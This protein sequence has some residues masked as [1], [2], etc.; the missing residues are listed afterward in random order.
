MRTTELLPVPYSHAGLMRQPLSQALVLR[1]GST[2]LTQTQ[3]E[4]QCLAILWLA[5]T[6][7]IALEIPKKLT[8]SL[9]QSCMIQLPA[10]GWVWPPQALLHCPSTAAVRDVFR[11][12]TAIMMT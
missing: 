5:R 7:C 2:L 10:R 1:S 6:V 4:G 8:V 9:C 3:G 11:F 12:K